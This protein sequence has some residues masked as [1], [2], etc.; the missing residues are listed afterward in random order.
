MA[1][2]TPESFSRRKSFR[3]KPYLGTDVLL[4]SVAFIHYHPYP[5][6]HI[7]LLANEKRSLFSSLLWNSPQRSLSGLYSFRRKARAGKGRLA[8]GSLRTGVSLEERWWF[9]ITMGE[10][11][12]G[13]RKAGISPNIAWSFQPMIR[14]VSS[15]RYCEISSQIYPKCRMIL[16]ANDKRS[17]FPSFLFEVSWQTL[18]SSWRI[19]E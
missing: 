8:T 19:L 7:I 18:I 2:P 4:K 12:D 16:P 11:R 1:S 10:F 15:Y 3:S 14:G 17:F 5:E 6:C 13:G 9:R